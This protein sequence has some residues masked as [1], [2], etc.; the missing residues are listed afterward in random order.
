MRPKHAGYFHVTSR[1]V[2]EEHIFRATADYGRRGHVFDSPYASVP[3]MEPEHGEVIEQYI[4]N[5]PPQRPWPWS[6][7]D[8]EFSFVERIPLFEPREPGS[9]QTNQVRTRSENAS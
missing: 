4:A 6:S 2:A 8:S 5:N 3:V 1:S 7:Y 9:S